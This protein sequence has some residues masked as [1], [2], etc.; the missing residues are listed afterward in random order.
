[1][2]ER[3]EEAKLANLGDRREV[4]VARAQWMGKGEGEAGKIREGGEA[5]WYRVKVG[6]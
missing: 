5:K 6:P 4:S 3:Q 2:V 1:M